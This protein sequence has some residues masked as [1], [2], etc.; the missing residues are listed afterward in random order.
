MQPESLSPHSQKHAK[1]PYPEADRFNRCPNHTSIRSILILY[2]LLCLGLASG[3]LPS[4]F[5]K[6]TLY[7]P[8]LSIRATFCA[9]F[10]IF[11]LIARLIF[12]EKYRAWSS[13]LCSLLHSPLTE[14]ILGPNTLLSTI[15]SKILSAF[16]PQSERPSFT[17]IQKKQAKL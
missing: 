14:S 16:L 9:Y 12:G 15:F 10:I 2:S 4:H 6:K 5:P 13:L 11:D 7:A 8:L 17:P 1:C 3:L